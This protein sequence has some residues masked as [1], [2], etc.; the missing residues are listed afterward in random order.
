MSSFKRGLGTILLEKL[1]DEKLFK[2]KLLKDIL[3][4]KNTAKEKKVFFAIRGGYCSFY[5]DGC[6]LFTYK[7]STFSTHYKYCFVPHEAK[8][9]YITEDDLKSGNWETEKSFINGYEKIKERAMLFA[10]IEAK[11]VS[12]LY[13]FAPTASNTSN[14]YFLVDTEV[15][16]SSKDEVDS[17]SSNKKSLNKI[18]IL[19]YDNKNRKLLFC[20]AKDFSNSE[21]WAKKNSKPKVVRQLERYNKQ[22]NQNETAILKEYTKAFKEYNELIGSSLNEPKSIHPRCGLLVFGFD[23]HQKEKINTLLKEDESLEDH[24]PHYVGD[25]R[26]NAGAKN[27]KTAET[28]FKKLT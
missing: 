11:G 9:D 25:I 18:D 16:F 5:V 10:N 23:S 4:A 14:Q 19:L 3:L 6:S 7:D 12:A 8:E 2:D 21:L 28:I 26:G 20:E 24:K 1:K 15:V 22:I 17:E 13:R 27:S